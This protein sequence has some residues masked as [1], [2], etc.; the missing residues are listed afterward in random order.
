[1]HEVVRASWEQNAITLITDGWSDTRSR[2]IHGITAYSRGQAYFISASDASEIGKTVEAL[3]KEWSNAIEVVGPEKVIQLV[4]TREPANRAAG[5][6]LEERYPHI[7]FSVCMAHCLNN[8]LEDLGRIEWVAKT[9]EKGNHIVSFIY[10]HTFLLAEFRKR[11]HKDLRKYL[12]T[13]S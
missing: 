2:S 3:F 9:I 5:R 4:T 10:R 6:L 8:L 13:T 11:L 7:T 12:D 1:M